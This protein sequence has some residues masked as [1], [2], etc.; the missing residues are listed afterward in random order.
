VADAEAAGFHVLVG[1]ITVGNTVSRRLHEALGF[2]DIGTMLEVGYKF[3]RWL[4]VW[5]V[6]KTFAGPPRE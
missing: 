1:R 6:Q 3:G 4:D 5:L 2:Q